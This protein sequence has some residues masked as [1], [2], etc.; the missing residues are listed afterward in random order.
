V[1]V[2]VEIVVEDVAAL[3]VA[4]VEVIVEVLVAVEV[5]EV[6]LEVSFTFLVSK[7]FQVTMYSRQCLYITYKL[8]RIHW[9]TGG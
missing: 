9:L 1:V 4:E 6:A 8:H 3:E 7:C 2:A 5:V